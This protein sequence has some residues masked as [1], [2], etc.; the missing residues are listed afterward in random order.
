M[1]SEDL[2][3]DGYVKWVAERMFKSWNVHGKI[4]DLTETDVSI[5]TYDDSKIVTINRDG[6]AVKDEISPATKEDVENYIEELI[7]EKEKE[8]KDLEF[9][10]KRESKSYNKEIKM[11][12]SIVL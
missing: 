4:V 9:E 5:L 2:K 11:L 10:F 7:H 12:K 1:K 8:L 6:E 3:E